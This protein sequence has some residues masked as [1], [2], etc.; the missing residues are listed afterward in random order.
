MTELSSESAVV[1]MLV[2]SSS[3]EVPWPSSMAALPILTVEFN[4]LWRRRRRVLGFFKIL[5]GGLKIIFGH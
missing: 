1:E 3:S 4:V 2:A 5:K